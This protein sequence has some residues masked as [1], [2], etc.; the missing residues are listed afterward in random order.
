MDGLE[1]ITDLTRVLSFE[2]GLRGDRAVCLC[3]SAALP[4]A[5]GGRAERAVTVPI[6]LGNRLVLEREPAA[7]EFRRSSVIV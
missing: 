1:R 7:G 3:G 5:Y 6:N 2:E 4:V